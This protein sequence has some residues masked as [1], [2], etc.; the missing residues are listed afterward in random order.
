MNTVR[1]DIIVTGVN[2]IF[3]LLVIFAIIL[4]IYVA[5]GNK[6]KPKKRK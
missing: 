5:I 3:L 6:S 4:T 1:A 2:T